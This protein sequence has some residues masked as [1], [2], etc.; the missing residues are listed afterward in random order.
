MMRALLPAVEVVSFPY[1]YS[2]VLSSERSAFGRIAEHLHFCPP[3]RANYG[4]ALRA[5][6]NR[7]NNYLCGWRKIAKLKF[8]H[9]DNWN[10]IQ[11]LFFS[12]LFKKK[13]KNTRYKRNRHIYREPNA[14]FSTGILY[15]GRIWRVG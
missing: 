3:A 7:F 6:I 9:S 10:F 1:I 13:K 2:I 11:L 12:K 8:L 4:D 15:N 5:R 14:T